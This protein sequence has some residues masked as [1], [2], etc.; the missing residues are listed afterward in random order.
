MGRMAASEVPIARCWSRFAQ[1]TWSG[2]RTKPPPTPSRPPANPATPPIAASRRGFET[3][4]PISHSRETADVEIHHLL[5]IEQFVARSLEPILSKHEDI[6]PLGVPQRLARV[7]LDDEHRHTGGADL[8]DAFPDEALEFRRQAGAGLVEDEHG[9]VDHQTS[10]QGQH[11]ALAAAQ[12]VG[13]A[14]RRS[15]EV[16]EQLEELLDPV[17]HAPLSAV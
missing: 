13:F 14:V 4:P 9:G 10:R 12:G 8:L 1:M 16:R 5:I 11:R 15:G 3:G 7:L 2:T 17:A 6:C